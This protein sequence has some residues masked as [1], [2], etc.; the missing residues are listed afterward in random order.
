MTAGL[1]RETRS[2]QQGNLVVVNFQPKMVAFLGAQLY[3]SV[4]QRNT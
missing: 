1:L 3:G 2:P 4:E